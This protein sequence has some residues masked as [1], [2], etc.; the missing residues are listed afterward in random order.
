VAYSK[1]PPFAFASKLRPTFESLHNLQESAS[2][3][4]AS[5]AVALHLSS[6]SLLSLALSNHA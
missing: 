6:F 2:L 4:A 1:S 3:F 5:L